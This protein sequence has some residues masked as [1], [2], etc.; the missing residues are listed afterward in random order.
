MGLM[1]VPR[2]SLRLAELVMCPSEFPC[3][4]GKSLFSDG[5]RLK[6]AC[7]A[8]NLHYRISNVPTFRMV[9]TFSASYERSSGQYLTTRSDLSSKRRLMFLEKDRI[10]PR[11]VVIL[12]ARLRPA[13]GMNSLG[14]SGHNIS[15]VRA[16]RCLVPP[17]D[18]YPES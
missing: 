14:S 11:D 13:F 18:V 7:C 12:E 10:L 17:E 4:K 1:G 15:R 3:I 9:W 8:L 6:A 2:A 5:A 16:P